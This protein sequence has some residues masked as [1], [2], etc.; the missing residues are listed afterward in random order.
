MNAR[1]GFSIAAHLDPDVLIIDEVLAVGD[2]RFQQKAFGRLQ[3]LAR[4]G[5]PVI[6]VSH[7]LDRIAELCSKAILLCV[8][9]SGT[10][11]AS[12]SNAL[13]HTWS[14]PAAGTAMETDA[15]MAFLTPILEPGHALTVGDPFAFSVRVVSVERCP[16][17]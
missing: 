5:R 4:S 2:F 10:R 13:P 16:T 15:P 7:Q 12:P 9:A 6:V 1:L 8:G 14:R 17:T 3:E 11:L